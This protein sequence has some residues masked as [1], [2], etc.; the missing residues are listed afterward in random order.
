MATD[1]PGCDKCS[2]KGAPHPMT[3]FGKKPKYMIVFDNPSYQEGATGKMLQGETSDILKALIKEVGM[4][5]NDAYYTSL[6]KSPK[7]K[8]AKTLTTEQ[9]NGCS[10]YLKSEI[11]IL[12]PPVILTLG[13]AAT[14]FLIPTAKNVQEMVGKIEFSAALDC[15]IVVGINPA[16]IYFDTSKAA[17]LRS[18]LEKVKDL[19]Y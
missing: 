8:G 10:P 9:I 18:V 4:S 13:S 7:P 6:V 16:Q 12:K 5:L 19:I 2:L 3:Q 17:I 1:L 14:K 11:E 15:S